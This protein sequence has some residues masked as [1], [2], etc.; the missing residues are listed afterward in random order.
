MIRN[1]SNKI[2]LVVLSY[3]LCFTFNNCTATV[4]IPIVKSYPQG[5]QESIG[6]ARNLGIFVARSEEQIIT[7]S[8]WKSLIQGEILN[9][10]QEKRYFRIIDIANRE[11]RLKELVFSQK[12]GATKTLSSEFAID[13]LLLIDVPQPPSSECNNFTNRIAKQQCVKLDSSGKCLRYKE[14]YLIE[15]TKGLVYSFYVRAKLVHLETGQNLEYTNSEPVIL[16]RTSASPNLDCP[17][18]LEALNDAMD[19]AAKEIVRRLSP[20]VEDVEIPVYKDDGGISKVEQKKSIIS[21]LESGIDWIK[22][23]SPNLEFAKKDWEKAVSLSSNSSLSALW[24]MGVYYWYKGDF[25][26]AD[27]YFK[28]VRELGSKEGWLNSRRRNSINLFEKERVRAQSA[29]PK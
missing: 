7:L 4:N 2:V 13:L 20:T 12:I 21:Y 5:F 17:S 19:A 25:T 22:G 29:V 26:R 11:A 6:Y 27:E 1:L 16:R 8:N 10:F 18:E 23:E 3:I 9:K 28:K 15:Y 24:N 14:V